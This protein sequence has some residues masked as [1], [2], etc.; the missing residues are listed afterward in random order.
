MLRFLILTFVSVNANKNWIQSLTDRQRIKLI[1]EDCGDVCDTT[2]PGRKGFYFDVIDKDIDCESLFASPMM[3]LSAGYSKPLM[4]EELP[5]EIRYQYSYNGRVEL[6]EHYLNDANGKTHQ[7]KWSKELIEMM[8]KLHRE[9]KNPGSYGIETVQNIDKHIKGHM[10]DQIQGGH[11]LVI[12]SQWPWLESVILENGA[13]HITTLEYE[14]LN[15]THPQITVLTPGELNRNV[16]DGKK[17]EFDAVVTFSSLEHSGLGR[18]GDGLNPWGDLIAS[19]KAWCLTKPGGR[20]LFGMPVLYDIVLFNSARVYGPLQLSHLF[21]N[22][23][24]VFTEAKEFPKGRDTPQE[25]R[26]ED[27]IFNY[28][29]LFV[30]EKPKIKNSF[31]ADL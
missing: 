1:K 16:M 13:K 17:Y 2:K 25:E 5:K 7:T 10:L 30:V 23:R 21:A 24:L 14:S 3:E 6:V 31:R 11:V 19:A 18:Y 22:W 12:G 26:P 8:R 28:Q 4:L 9:G 29:P 15:C 20:G 27:F